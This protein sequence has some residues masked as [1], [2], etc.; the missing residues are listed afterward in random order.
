MTL[1]ELK[2]EKN[3]WA[4]LHEPDN[5]CVYWPNI[6]DQSNVRSWYYAEN[7]VKVVKSVLPT[8]SEFPNLSLPFFNI[9]P[10]PWIGRWNVERKEELPKVII[11]ALNPSIG[12][13]NFIDFDCESLDK[14]RD[15]GKQYHK[16]M[17]KIL[18]GKAS[19][20]E[21]LL[22]P[23]WQ[24]YNG[25][26]WL[27][28]LHEVLNVH[29]SELIITKHYTEDIKKI[30]DKIMFIELCPYHSLNGA[31]M[32]TLLG[33]DG[34]TCK[35]PSM[36]FTI[37]LVKMLKEEGRTILITRSLSEWTKLIDGL[38]NYEKCYRLSSWQNTAI[39]VGNCC[40]MGKVKDGV[41]D[42]IFASLK[43]E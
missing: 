39:T 42:K 33:K 19:T 36:N 32:R 27:E 40:T 7:D 17:K 1:A 11:L 41:F 14:A 34:A 30:L 2:S 10:Q 5:G 29:P 31:A 21:I 9:D 16:L 28:K 24:H 22:N 35:F 15:N 37:S 23:I 6:N 3:P 26:Y 43:G 20:S 8:K 4:I 18:S 13:S 38:Y 25:T 12:P